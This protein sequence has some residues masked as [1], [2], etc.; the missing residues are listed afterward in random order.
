MKILDFAM[1]P[2]PI[3]L[4]LY[5]AEKGLNI[6][7]GNVDFKKGEHRQPGFLKKNPLGAVPVLGLENGSYLTESLVIMEYLEELYPEPCMIGRTPLERA[8]TRQIERF[9]ELNIFNPVAQIFFHTQPFFSDKNQVFAIADAARAK[10]PVVLELLDLKLNG[11]EFVTA[12]TPTIA[13]CTLFA[14]CIHAK[15]VDIDLGIQYKNIKHWH[16]SFSQRNSVKRI[17]LEL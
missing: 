15:R 4:R 5:C 11:R 12:N 2:N 17:N 3:K 10:L 9:I 1:A 6:P 14:A 7:F 13:D 16:H 8:Y